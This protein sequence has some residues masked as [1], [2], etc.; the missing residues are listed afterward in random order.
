MGASVNTAAC[1]RG[2]VPGMGTVMKR[3]TA[4]AL[5]AICAALIAGALPTLAAEREVPPPAKP[6][7]P[8]PMKQVQ[9]PVYKPPAR[10]MP[11]GRVGGG[12]RGTRERDVFVLSV[13]APDHTGLTTKEQPCLFWFISTRTALPVELTIIDPAV[14]GSVLETRL[15]APV[16]RGVHRVRL[17]EHGVRLRM[18]VAY[19][20]SVTVVP[21]PAHR[22]RDILASGTIERVEADAG[23][24]QQLPGT[25]VENLAAVYAQAGIWYDALEAIS[26]VIDGA[27]KDDTLR[28]Y[29]AELLAQVGLPRVGE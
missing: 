19:Q 9:A 22:S 24:K 7:A 13:L 14:V 4:V 25:R 12:T 21:D 3:S 6:Q 20:W 18:G 2:F 1:A 10:G 11:G 15:S 28:R 26:D 23:L 5:G 16:E 27:P 17:A 29:R 8:A